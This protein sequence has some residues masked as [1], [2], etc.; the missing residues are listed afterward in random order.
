MAVS[1]NTGFL[2]KILTILFN[3]VMS[4]IFQSLFFFEWYII[5]HHHY[6]DNRFHCVRKMTP[7]EP[8]LQLT[9]D[10]I[11]GVLVGILSQTGF[12][13]MQKCHFYQLI[14][15][16]TKS[17]YLMAS[18]QSGFLCEK[19]SYTIKYV[20]CFL[21]AC[22]SLSSDADILLQPEKRQQN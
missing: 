16:I 14:C 15:Q 17:Q 10:D 6:M 3:D 4:I 11:T 19:F 12:K 7:R 2:V 5:F 18:P 1:L 20:K 21:F 9:R 13:V 8:E 22:C